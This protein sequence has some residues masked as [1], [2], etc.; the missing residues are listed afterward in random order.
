MTIE[1]HSSEG[2][3]QGLQAAELPRNL[4][5]NVEMFEEWWEWLTQEQPSHDMG[6]LPGSEA[7]LAR[8]LWIPAQSLTYTFEG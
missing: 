3:S 4:F 2:V 6:N 8:K 7:R 5:L 1:R